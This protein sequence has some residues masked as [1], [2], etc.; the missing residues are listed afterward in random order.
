MIALIPGLIAGI[1]IALVI[2]A[3]VPRQPQLAAA[4]ERVEFGTPETA[5]SDAEMD[6]RT[7]VGTW[8]A[9][10]FPAAAV[11]REDL[12]LINK[13]VES[14]YYDKALSA[15][16]GFVIPMLSG[17]AGQAFGYL[18]FYIPTIIG[19]PLAVV[20]WLSVDQDIKKKAADARLEFARGVAV[21]LE[22]F[23]ARKRG[24]TATD[25]LESAAEVGNSWVFRR[26]RQALHRARYA[27]VASWDALEQLGGDIN[28]PQLV[29]MAK[30]VRLNGERDASV[31]E[32][33]RAKGKSLRHE[34]LNREHEQANTD[35]E[36]LQVPLALSLGIY[37]GII[38]TPMIINLF[39][40]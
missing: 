17:L 13:S 18:A 15:V 20:M 4:I 37:A 12:R 24:T 5:V 16:T 28:V 35:S 34:L 8:L 27:G 22:L 32:T 33:A 30:I 9:K 10:R 6:F 39:T 31:Y 21:Y 38:L 29:E 14:Y 19:I 7:R 36:R 1:G 3:V 25:A 26:I 23:A 11:P 40:A 2:A